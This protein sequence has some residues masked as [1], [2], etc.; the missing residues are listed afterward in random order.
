MCLVSQ[1]ASIT[2]DVV[3]FLAVVA[4]LSVLYV[5]L[6]IGTKV[7][8]AHLCLLLLTPIRKV[9][10]H[11]VLALMFMPHQGLDDF[12]SLFRQKPQKKLKAT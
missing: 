10:T 12:L 1:V 8:E 3:T 2:F 11:V 6:H 9:L 7:S 4:Y 5:S